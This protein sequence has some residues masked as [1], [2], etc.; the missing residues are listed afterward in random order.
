[1]IEVGA[2]KYTCEEPFICFNER[3]KKAMYI[4]KCGSSSWIRRKPLCIKLYLINFSTEFEFLCGN[5]H[6]VTFVFCQE[7]R[8]LFKYLKSSPFSIYYNLVQVFVQGKSSLLELT[9]KL[10]TTIFKLRYL[11]LAS[12]LNHPTPN[13]LQKISGMSSKFSMKTELGTKSLNL[14]QSRIKNLL[15]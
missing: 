1:M 4:H 13:P 15:V 10:C 14:F 11:L 5:M 3:T 8:A 2:A 9:E 7:V 6:D 12:Y